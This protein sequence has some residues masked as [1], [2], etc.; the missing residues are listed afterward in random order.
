MLG[1]TVI[2]SYYKSL[3]NLKIILK[4][5]NNQ[6][7]ID[8]EVILSED[9]NNDETIKY[10]QEIKPKLN[11]SI[12]HLNQEEDTGFKKNSML[13]K[14]IIRA[15]T[16]KI[17][18][19]DGDCIPHKHFVKQYIRCIDKESFCV[20]RAVMLDKDTTEEIKDCQDLGIL[21]FYK[22]LFSKSKKMKDGIYFPY[23]HL[24][25][26]TKGLVGRNW[27][28]HKK[29]LIEI[30]GF[31]EDYKYACLGEDT[32]IEWRLIAHG[33]RRKSVKNMAI[34]YHLYHDRW[35]VEE[36]TEGNRR[37]LEEKITQNEI[38]CINGIKYI[39]E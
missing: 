2:I 35:Y 12:I 3:N 21:N 32:D 22:L 29:S 28:C 1:L 16:E 8:F 36:G 26:K 17:A 5:L 14:S 38:K 10:I 9:D 6:S 33:I 7:C 34:V 4:A 13:N 27:G 30:N 20:G 39:G 37:I 31:D 11:F 25:L 24:S 18:F 15:N 23:F 19:I